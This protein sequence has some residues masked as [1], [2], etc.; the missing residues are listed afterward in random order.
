MEAGMKRTW[1]GPLVCVLTL[2]VVAALAFAVGGVALAQG[3]EPSVV[4]PLMDVLGMLASGIGVGAV[5]AFLFER[6][7]WFQNMAP[8]TK[9]WTIFLLSLGLPVLA[10]VALQFMP[11]DIWA[12]IE[13][14]WISLATGF[15]VWAGSQAFHLY[16]RRAP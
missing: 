10:R 12:K 3:T 8:N 6:I 15:L 13:P 14:Y 1:I 5:I 4:P 7:K 16:S 9:W 2:L 11:P